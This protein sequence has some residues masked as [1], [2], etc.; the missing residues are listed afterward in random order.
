MRNK[1]T[2][3]LATAIAMAIMTSCTKDEVEDLTP[4]NNDPIEDTTSVTP[5]DSTDIVQD[6]TIAFSETVDTV[7][8]SRYAGL[9]YE[10]GS[11]PQIFQIGCN[12]TT[13]EYAGISET[14]ISVINAC[15]LF[16]PSGFE[17]RIEG[18]ATIVPN[19]GNAKLLVSFFGGGGADYWIID[20]EP[21]YNWAVVGSGD[22]QSFWILSRTRTFDDALYDSLLAK[23]GARGYDVS[24]VVRSRQD[25]C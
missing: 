7:I 19:S 4:V 2:Y 17:N 20:L 9:W 14:Q 5:I 3:F 25:G 21:D 23:W 12:C 13:A 1:S 22:K 6:T 15:N 16:S 8:I 24:R 18:T 10:I 11:I